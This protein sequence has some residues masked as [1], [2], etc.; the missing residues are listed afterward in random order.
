MDSPDMGPEPFSD[1]GDTFFEEKLKEKLQPC[2]TLEGDRRT[3]ADQNTIWR[4]ELQ[5]VQSLHR[6]DRSQTN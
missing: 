4:L 3:Q 6:S 2:E 1:L 5:K